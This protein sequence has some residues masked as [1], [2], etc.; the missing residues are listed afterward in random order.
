MHGPRYTQQ[1]SPSQRRKRCGKCG[2][3]GW[4]RPRERR[5][6]FTKVPGGYAC[7]G[8]L[9][10]IRRRKK[11][12]VPTESP[13]L[14]SRGATYRAAAARQLASHERAAKALRTRIKRLQ[15]ALRKRDAQVRRWTR[16]AA[17]TDEQVAAIQARTD[18]ARQV[19]RMRRRLQ[20]S[21]LGA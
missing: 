2:S 21:A 11:P 12:L 10:A 16:E 20:K 1:T 5:C 15:T 19:Q 6:K 18:H 4:Y 14:A 9:T 3:V 17:R 13:T 7:W 8:P